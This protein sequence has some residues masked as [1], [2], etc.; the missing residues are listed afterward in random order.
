MLIGTTTA[1]AAWV[2]SEDGAGLEVNALLRRR[3]QNRRF[4]LLGAAAGL[5]ITVALLASRLNFTVPF[6]GIGLAALAALFGL[7]RLAGLYRP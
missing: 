1:L 6:G 4:I 7:Y 2:L 3:F 5:A